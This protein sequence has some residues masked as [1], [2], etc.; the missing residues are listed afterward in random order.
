M[1]NTLLSLSRNLLFYNKVNLPDTFETRL[2][3]MFMHFSIMMIIFK[4]KGK[5]F[6]QK[7]YDFFFHSIEY[8]L[9]ES[10][11][12]DVSVNKK[13]KDFNKIMYDIL[14]KIENGE[15]D[16]KKFKINKILINKYFTCFQDNK[17]T[18]YL[19]FERYFTDFFYFC[20]EL[21]LENM[22]RDAINFNYGCS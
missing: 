22:V 7:D 6:A 2:Y 19:I 12:G 15:K 9:R 1:Y 5:K 10:G 21:P 4:K 3:L 13:M 11:L 20:F 18:K 17:D 14:L 16:P 8:N